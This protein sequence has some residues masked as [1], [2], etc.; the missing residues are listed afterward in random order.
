MRKCNCII[1]A[2]P[3]GRTCMIILPVQN[4]FPRHRTIPPI[5]VEVYG[6]SEVGDVR[7]LGEDIK[8]LD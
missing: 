1:S 3:V 7:R 6:V 5:G 2:R 4:F 8:R